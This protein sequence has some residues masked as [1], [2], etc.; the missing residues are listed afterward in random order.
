M[1]HLQRILATILQVLAALAGLALVIGDQAP[2]LGL[3]V[4]AAALTALVGAATAV[5]ATIYNV[6]RQRGSTPILRTFLQIL[7][8]LVA[9]TPVVVGLLAVAGIHIDPTQ[10]AAVGAVAIAAVTMIMNIAEANGTIPELSGVQ[11]TFD[12]GVPVDPLCIGCEPV[13]PHGKNPELIDDGEV[14]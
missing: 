7:I 13:G 4:D 1:S 6:V 11:L 10:I 8:A 14:R 12:R 2:V 5:V 9:V 3:D